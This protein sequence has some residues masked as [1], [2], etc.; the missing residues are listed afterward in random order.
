MYEEEGKVIGVLVYMIKKKYGLTYIL[1][2]SLCP[3]M[4]PLFFGKTINADPSDVSKV[5]SQL[6]NQLPNHHLMIQE[7]FHSIPHVDNVDSLTQKKYTYIVAHDQ[8]AESLKSSLKPDRRRRIRKAGELFTYEEVD[9]FSEF[10]TFLEESFSSREKSNPY[11]GGTMA[12][13]D[14]HLKI[15]GA[16][17]IIKATDQGGKTI[18]MEYLLID[19]KWIYNLANGIRQDYRHD[20]LSYILW[21][22][23]ENALAANKSF[24]FEGSVIPGI[25][26]FFQSLRGTKTI[27]QSVYK[28]KNVLIDALVRFKNP[29]I[30]S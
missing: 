27:Y 20:A 25:E 13:L 30:L 19:E 4:G 12:N 2:P 6:I 15:K 18:A 29:E 22:E 11:R 24:D 3:Y 21:T 17:K 7:Y 26:R 23:I 9:D 28:S 1:H 10:E 5:Y 16:R 14:Q 8:N